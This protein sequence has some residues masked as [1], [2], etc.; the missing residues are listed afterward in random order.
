MLDEFG[1]FHP[2][3][4]KRAPEGYRFAPMK[5][6]SLLRHGCWWWTRGQST[7][8]HFEVR[9]A[10]DPAGC[11][12]SCLYQEVWPDERGKTV[13]EAARNYEGSESLHAFRLVKE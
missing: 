11:V 12:Y 2:R 10:L 8:H 5:R 13:E 4:L 1:F 6:T 7:R 9:S 3:S